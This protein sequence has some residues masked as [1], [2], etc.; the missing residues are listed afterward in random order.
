MRQLARGNENYRVSYLAKKSD[1][2]ENGKTLLTS[3]LLLV[4][5]ATKWIKAS[6]MFP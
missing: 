1:D 4:A 3:L 5:E 2:G 6:V